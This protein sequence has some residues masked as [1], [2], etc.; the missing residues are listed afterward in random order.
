[1]GMGVIV[2]TEDDQGNSS[3]YAKMPTSGIA[4]LL[5]VR[6]LDTTGTREDLVARLIEYEQKQEDEATYETKK[7]EYMALSK[8]AL[9]KQAKTRGL[10]TTGSAEDILDRLLQLVRSEIFAHD[11]D[12]L[13]KVTK[14][15]EEGVELLSETAAEAADRL[16]EED[17]QAQIAEFN[18]AREQ[19]QE[20]MLQQKEEF[21]AMKMP[22]LKKELAERGLETKGK[23][24]ELLNRLADHLAA[25]HDEEMRIMKASMSP[26]RSTLESAEADRLAEEDAQAQIAEFNAAREQAQ[27]HMLQQKEGFSAMKMPALKKELAE[28]GLETKGKK[29]ELLNR[30]TD[31]LAA[32]HDEEMRIMKASMPSSDAVVASSVVDSQDAA[33]SVLSDK[34]VE[35]EELKDKYTAMPKAMIK[36]YLKKRGLITKGKHDELLTR[37]LVVVRAEVFADVDEDVALAAAEE[38][39]RLAEDEAIADFNATRKQA[40]EHMRQ[41]NEAFVDMT[42][43]SLRKEL[44]ERGLETKGKKTELL[45]RLADHLAAEHDEEMRMLK[46]SKSDSPAGDT[47]PKPELALSLAEEEAKFEKKKADFSAM[48]KANIKK[49]LKKRGL[50]TKGTHDELLERLL[51]VVREEIFAHKE[52]LISEAE[53]EAERIAWEAEQAQIAQFNVARAQAQENM[54]QQKEEFVDMTKPALKKELNKRGLQT[55]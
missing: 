11:D 7:S 17:A 24:T 25:E 18:A 26:S 28:R 40:Q 5:K 19:A 54:R 34:E 39:E 46:T 30:L 52:K 8:G 35:F 29:M 51:E 12:E 45:N 21:S 37:L 10:E 47:A 14:A 49:R 36:T 55:K 1:M 44:A 27:E 43:P 15:D 4:K 16:A 38:V 22:A 50:E 32:E 6:N 48:P 2:P 33:P 31:H 13:D 41:Q 9:K 23:K 20:H 3:K 42:K 53:A